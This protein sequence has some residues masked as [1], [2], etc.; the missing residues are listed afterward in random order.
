MPTFGAWYYERPLFK[1]MRFVNLN[2]NLGVLADYSCEL[3]NPETRP[4]YQV[5]ENDTAYR[6]HLQMVENYPV[7]S[8]KTNNQFNKFQS[9][10][11]IKSGKTYFII[12][13]IGGKEYKYILDSG[14]S[15]MTIDENSYYNL[16]QSGAINMKDKLPNGDYK[17][18][19]GRIE[20]YVRTLIPEIKVGNIKVSQ[21]SA[22][23]VP[24][25]QPLLLGKS[26]LDN[27]K[28]WKIDNVKNVLIVEV[29]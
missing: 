26:F 25:G 6:F 11:L 17:M 13:S 7:F 19:D 14:A 12:V 5:P 8:S 22:S 10:P 2:E 9:I 27:F 23:V 1:K 3:S 29:E 20:T 4:D 16:I 21:V 28:T 15:D 24:S 18:A